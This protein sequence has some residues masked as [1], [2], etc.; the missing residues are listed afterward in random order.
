MNRRPTV[1]TK[2]IYIALSGR[3]FEAL[4]SDNLLHFVLNLTY[5]RSKD[6]TRTSSLIAYSLALYLSGVS[7]SPFVAG[8]FQNFTISFLIAL[9]LFA[10][11]IVYLLV[12]AAGPRSVW[13]SDSSTEARIRQ[14][15]PT[16]LKRFIRTMLTPLDSFHRYPST[17][18]VGFALLAYNIVQSYIFNALLV[19]TS[20]HFQFTGRENGLLISLVHV[21][22]AVYIM[23]A[24]YIIPKIKQRLSKQDAT[25]NSS[26]QFDQN[27]SRDTALALIS[28]FFGTLSL[29]GIGFAE[30]PGQIYIFTLMLA[31][32]L[33]AS[34][35]IKTTFLAQFVGHERDLGLASLAAMETFGSVLGPMVLGGFQSFCSSEY[36]VFFAAATLTCISGAMFGLNAL[37]SLSIR[38]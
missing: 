10:I 22:A 33:P 31:L 21:V 13:R 25:Q 35:F 17:R 20:L 38:T 19:H 36:V 6:H 32:S 30:T 2:S 18:L 4:A 16:A 9:C 12:F 15:T 23:L 27:T 26:K 24:T 11:A 8:L 29:V 7:I 1:A 37:L 5:A 3:I 14:N 28:L 34:A